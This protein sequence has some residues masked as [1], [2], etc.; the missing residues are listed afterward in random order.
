MAI[1]FDK[2]EVS[3]IGYSNQERSTIANLFNCRLGS[4]LIS[5]LDL[6]LSDSRILMKD[7]RPIVYRVQHRVDSWQDTRNILISLFAFL[8]TLNNLQEHRNKP[9][10]ETKITSC[11]RYGIDTLISIKL[12]LN[13]VH[14][15]DI[16]LF[17][18]LSPGS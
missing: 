13:S 10:Q 2:N 5:Y 8:W 1:N 4:I 3:V 15:Q 12:Q 14:L 18:T 7:L 11:A 9:L 17:L 16:K 6:P